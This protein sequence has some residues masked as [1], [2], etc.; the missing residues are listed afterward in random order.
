MSE[1]PSTT[2][3][4]NSL[5]QDVR[6]LHARCEQFFAVAKAAVDLM[7]RFNGTRGRF[8]DEPPSEDANLFAEWDTLGDGLRKLSVKATSA[9]PEE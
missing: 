6:A 2:K 1:Y 8:R 5:Q 4:I 3:L 7:D 9:T